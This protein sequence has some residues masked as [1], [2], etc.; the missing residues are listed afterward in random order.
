MLISFR[1]ENHRSIRDEQAF[2]MEPGRVDDG[3]APVRDADGDS[4]LSVAAIY[5]P[6]ASGKSNLLN[7]LAFMRSAVE[8]SHRFYA[9]EGG[10]PRRAFA[11][12]PKAAEPSFFEVVFKAAGVRYEYGF[13]ADD[14]RFLEEWLH[15]YPSSRKQVWFERDGNDFKFGEH[16]NGENRVVEK[17]TRPNSLFLSA[18]I[19]NRHE[20]LMPVF[21]WFRSIQM[22][23]VRAMPGGPG[24][25]AQD[26]HFIHWWLSSSKGPQGAGLEEDSP[27]DVNVR[28]E[29]FRTLLH[30][31]DVGVVDLRVRERG[32]AGADR[33]S[34]MVRHQ[35]EI[36][37]AWLPLEEESH[38]TRQLFKLA[39]PVLDALALGSP[40]LIDELEASLHPL[41]ALQLV[42]TF[43]NLGQ[44]PHNAQLI[45][46]THDTSLLGTTTGA[47]ALR[48]D[49]IWLTE[50]DENGASHIYPLTDYKPRKAENLER[51]Y[52]QGRY[53]AIPFL[54]E[55]VASM[56]SSVRP[57]LPVSSPAAAAAATIAPSP[58]RTA[59][60]ATR[61]CRR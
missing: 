55:L 37:E 61:T 4:I 44:N 21:R 50:K 18:A 25:S 40:V 38:G 52:L 30:A 9:P 46:T 28:A 6:N 43:S 33:S 3:E 27:L 57:P 59:P 36:E 42:Q 54:E 45:F 17:V 60:R 5:G 31:A 26:H 11:W 51:G 47:P 15:A 39:P 41:L 19:Q 24:R 23:N 8:Y 34:V 58:R 48:R 29:H 2:S 12:G 53:G 16:L 22:H 7:G 56:R 49:Q 13:V 1:L 35:S 14:M 32:E 20:Q 10:V